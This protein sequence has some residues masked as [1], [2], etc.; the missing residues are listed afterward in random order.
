MNDTIVTEIAVTG[1]NCSWCFNETVERLRCEPGVVAV[2]AS[3]TG[4]CLHVRHHDVAVDRL[5]EVI[6]GHLHANDLSTLERVMDE[7]EPAVVALHCHHHEHH[8]ERVGGAST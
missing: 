1:A 5:L 7:V 6:R 3:I 4:Q 8:T 2:D